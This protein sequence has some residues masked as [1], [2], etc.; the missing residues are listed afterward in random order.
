MQ[1]LAFIMDGNRR[2]AK[3]AGFAAMQGHKQG[4]EAAKLAIEFCI[5]RGI[6]YLSLYTFSLE[7]FSRSVIEQEV[8]FSI[9]V[10][11]ITH[12]LDEFIDQGVRI[13]FVGDRS[14]FP[15]HLRQAIIDAELKTKSL[16]ELQLNILFCYGG[17][18]ELVHAVK[19]IA[20]KVA[21][22][23][24]AVSD[25]NQDTI[26]DA[27]WTAG[28]PNPDLIVRTSGVNRLSNFLLYQ[29]AYSELAFLDCHWPEITEAH[30]Q[31]CVDDFARSNR[32]F[33]A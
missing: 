8:I 16:T 11:S 10:D 28:V 4:K 5:K 1:H 14:K 25:I 31:K 17:Q 9:L 24:L 33:G 27:L 32:N 18:Q 23:E 30:L 3:S 12:G 7:N 13:A 22:G 21:A 19:G 6:K 26:S 15:E 20:T 29:A 2:W